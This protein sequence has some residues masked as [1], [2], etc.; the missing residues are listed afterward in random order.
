MLN[1]NKHDGLFYEQS[2]VFVYIK[3]ALLSGCEKEGRMEMVRAGVCGRPMVLVMDDV[4]NHQSEGVRKHIGRIHATFEILKELIKKY[5]LH[6]RH[7]R[8]VSG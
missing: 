3:T 7:V 8:T 4:R 6:L 5:F 2:V 1:D